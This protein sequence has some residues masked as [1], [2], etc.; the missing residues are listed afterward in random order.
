M[1][2][3]KFPSLTPLRALALLRELDEQAGWLR[4]NGP[5]RMPT[6]VDS[7]TRNELADHVRAALVRGG[8]R[9]R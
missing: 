2:P 3:P 8:K 6:A 1:K 7:R 5:A 9:K 4:G